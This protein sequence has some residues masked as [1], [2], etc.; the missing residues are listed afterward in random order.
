MNEPSPATTD[1][2]EPQLA[3]PLLS[4]H[5]ATNV[6]WLAAAATTAAE[7]ALGALY[8]VLYLKD[9]SGR[10]QAVSPA[11]Q[12]PTRALT[13]LGQALQAD[14]TRLKFD[15]Q[16]RTAVAM[17]LQ[18]GRV[19]A[20]A[21]LGRALPLDLDADTL[22][23]AQRR[24]GVSA[25]WLVPLWREGEALGLLVLLMGAS[26]PGRLASAELL[27]RHVA[28]ALRNL[29]EQEA[30]RKSGEVDAVRWVYDERR[31]LEELEQEARRA[32]RHKRPLSVLLLHILNLRELRSRYGRFLAERVLRQVAG[33]L[34]D[35]M[36]DTDFLGASQEDGFAVILVE[37]DQAGAERA[38][39]RLAASLHEMRLP[40]T[41][42][43]GLQVELAFATATQPQDGERAEELV[44][45]A[46][47]RLNGDKTNK[48]V[49]ATG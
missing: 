9:A 12:G 39:E 25:V 32:L 11:A 41:E 13:R 17:V 21:D 7:R 3:E 15:P 29:R 40:H 19:G 14:V 43:P 16:E 20:V 33:R 5:S 8:G 28:V 2:L 42:L 23:R 49:A 44:A 35:A 30:G 45:A 6:A 24:L 1:A 38:E 22:K 18:E 37:T 46:E 31:F 47:A 4:V 27:G 36:R 48:Q 10:L 34:D 26:P